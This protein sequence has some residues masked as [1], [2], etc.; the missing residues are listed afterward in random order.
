MT[1]ARRGSTGRTGAKGK[2]NGGEWITRQEAKRL[3]SEKGYELE[4]DS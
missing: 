3:A 4:E 1:S 2:D